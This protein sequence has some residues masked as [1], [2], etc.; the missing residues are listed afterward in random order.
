LLDQETDILWGERATVVLE[1]DVRIS[2]VQVCFDAHPDLAIDI[3]VL[4]I[5]DQLPDPAP[6]CRRR[7]IH[8]GTELR[9]LLVDFR[10]DVTVVGLVLRG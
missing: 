6:W 8:A 3:H 9:H 7:C 5:L 1:G 4:G 10:R 2:A